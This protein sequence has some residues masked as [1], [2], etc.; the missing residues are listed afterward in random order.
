MLV[1]SQY[2]SGADPVSAARKRII[3]A[4]PRALLKPA[5]SALGFLGSGLGLDVP[6]LG[7]RAWPGGTCA[8]VTPPSEGAVEMEVDVLGCGGSGGLL[9]GG[10]GGSLLGA[11]GLAP[12]VIT[13]GGIRVQSGYMK[14][15]QMAARPVL[16]VSCAVDL[17]AAT[18][19]EAK[20]LVERIQALMRDPGLMDR[21]DEANRGGGK[22]KS[23]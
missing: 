2:Q 12:V 11:S 1:L 4:L 3:A 7:V 21:A 20:A 22:L 6:S 23:S 17:R 15:K 19:Y 16:H 9:A 13:V 10:G 5:E 14:D 8:V 18:V